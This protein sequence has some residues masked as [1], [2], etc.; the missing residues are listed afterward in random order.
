MEIWQ[1]R[2]GDVAVIYVKGDIDEHTAP[3]IRA[4][5]DRVIGEGAKD[6][7]FCLR[8]V[9]FMD[10][11]GIGMLLGRFKNCKKSNSRL[12]VKDVNDRIDKIFKISGIYQVVPKVN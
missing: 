8:Y 1:K 5:A 6:V 4:F 3:E 12:F 10:S 2:D 9:D 11:T 7:V